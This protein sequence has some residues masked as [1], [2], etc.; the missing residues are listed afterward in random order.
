MPDKVKKNRNSAAQ[1]NRGGKHV[2]HKRNAQE[3]YNHRGGFR[4]PVS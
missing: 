2:P 1:N 3:K 4:Q